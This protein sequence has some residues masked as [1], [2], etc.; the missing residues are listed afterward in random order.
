[1][2]WIGSLLCGIQIQW[3]YT[4]I[5]CDISMPDFH[6]EALNKFQHP[7]PSRPQ[8][9][10]HSWKAPTYGAKIQYADA[11]DQSPLSPP[12]SIHLVQQI[13]RTLLYYAIAT[14][15]TMIVALGTLSSQHS[16]VTKQTYDVTLWLLN[17]ANSNPK[18]TISFTVS[19]MI[20]HIHSN[21]LYVSAPCARSCAGGHYF[22]AS[23]SLIRQSLPELAR[24][25][26]DPFTLC[27][28]SC[29]T[30]WDRPLKPKT[31]PRISMDRKPSP[32]A[33]YYANLATSSWPH[34]CK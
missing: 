16:K 6:K 34:P 9:A 21:T 30:S 27:L 2:D 22:S 7:N 8:N 4:A 33:H 23:A 25:S 24:V 1:M 15:P 5:T 18:A 14:D 19:D 3:D 31:A 12:K 10:P 17:Y 28:K 20:L 13:V 32:S 26:M 29:P 11:D